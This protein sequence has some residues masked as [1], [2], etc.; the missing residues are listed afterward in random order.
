MNGHSVQITVPLAT[1]MLSHDIL[2]DADTALGPWSMAVAVRHGATVNMRNTNPGL[3][4]SMRF[5]RASR[6]EAGS[7]HVRGRQPDRNCHWKRS[8][9]RRILR[10]PYTDR[11][12]DVR[13]LQLTIVLATMLASGVG[14]SPAWSDGRQRPAGAG[15]TERHAAR[16]LNS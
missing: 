16:C 14:A 13:D 7:R 9:Y 2:S 3:T 5:P 15:A 6:S 12:N 8:C 11:D 1:S 4:V 10:S